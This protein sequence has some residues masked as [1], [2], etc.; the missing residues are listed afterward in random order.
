VA[1]ALRYFVG[2][3]LG[4]ISDYTAIAVLRRPRVPTGTTRELRRPAYE[5][6]YLERLPLGTSYPEVVQHMLR[7]LNTPELRGC[8]FVVDQTGVGRPVVDMLSERM[9]NQVTCSFAPI[10]ITAGHHV[11][12]S[13]GLGLHVPKK[14]LVGVLQVLLQSRRLHI[15]RSLPHAATLVRELENFRVKITAARNEVYEAWREGAH[16]DL[17]LATAL[18]AWCAEK[19]LPPLIDPP[20]MPRHTHVGARR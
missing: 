8:F 15:A 4:Q 7:L 19:G 20:A 17:V 13:G 11:T 9:Q 10:T 3:D 14:E 12:P 6:P 2:F 18:A 5:L 1:N 16:D